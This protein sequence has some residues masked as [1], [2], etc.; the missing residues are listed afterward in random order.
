MESGA[1]ML[2]FCKKIN[3]HYTIEDEW[4]KYKNYKAIN[5]LDKETGKWNVSKLIFHGSKKKCDEKAH[6]LKRGEE[7]ASESKADDLYGSLDENESDEDSK[8]KKKKKIFSYIPIE[9][10]KSKDLSPPL[11][12]QTYNSPASPPRSRSS[13]NHT[14][15]P[16]SPAASPRPNTYHRPVSP[17]RSRTYQSPAASPRPNTYH[18]P[19]SPPRSRT[20]QSPAASPRTRSNQK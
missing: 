20:Y 7:K 8:P 9:Q 14:A 17:P 1:W 15:S 13:Q 16:H 19:V 5:V 12:D 3:K 2:L 6:S 4:G 18:R 11:S 10:R